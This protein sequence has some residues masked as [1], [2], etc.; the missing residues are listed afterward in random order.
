MKDQV[1]FGEL[2]QHLRLSKQGFNEQ[3]QLRQWSRRT[4]ATKANISETTLQN[5]E[6]GEQ[7]N[8]QQYVEALANALLLTEYQKHHFYAVAGMIYQLEPS[9]ITIEQIWGILEKLDCPAYARTAL[10]DFIAFNDYHRLLWEYNDQTLE[11][12]RSRENGKIGANLLRV[13]FEEDFQSGLRVRRVNDRVKRA[14]KVFRGESF[15]FISNPRYKEI[16]RYFENNLKFQQAWR[17]SEDD[18][19]SELDMS[20][21]RTLISINHPNYGLLEFVSTR[22]PERYIGNFVTLSVY[23]PI[24]VRHEGWNNFLKDV[25]PN[26]VHRFPQLQSPL[27]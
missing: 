13:L 2:V 16:I 11:I 7:P 23:H 25:N 20:L 12:L 4:L 21:D 26:L 5:I 19:D 3:G 9:K 6:K 22:I 17:L 15:R 24:P 18:D 10:W 14:I 1:E 27:Y 8:Y